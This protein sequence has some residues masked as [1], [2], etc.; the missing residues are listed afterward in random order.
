MKRCDL[1]KH[2]LDIQSFEEELAAYRQIK[3]SSNIVQ[4]L[5]VVKSNTSL[6][7]IMENCNGGS[8]EPYRRKLFRKNELLVKKV[9]SQILNALK[10][11]HA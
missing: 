4:V 2:K 11:T 8:L 1:P 5:D 6:Y 7:I 3:T 9:G 10:S